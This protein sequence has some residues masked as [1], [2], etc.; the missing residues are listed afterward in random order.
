MKLSELQNL[1]V[2][3]IGGW[4]APVKGLAI[5]FLCAAILGLGWYLD[6]S[7]Q[8]AALDEAERKEAELLDS[9]RFKQQKAANLEALKEQLAEIKTSFG[10]MLRRLPKK[11]EVAALLTDISQQGLG[12]GLEFELFKPGAEQPKDFYVELPIQIRVTG[13][14]HQFGQFVSG[15]A[16]LSRI[17][18]QQDIKITNQ[19]RKQVLVMETTAKTYRYM[20]AEEEAA[21]QT[22]KAK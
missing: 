18:T 1:D 17:V 22:Q 3:N 8:I 2:E 20:D 5:A 21:V 13:N 10:D 19:Q 11:A 12:A 7:N 6:W 16:D 4:P 15:V 9:L 14:Y